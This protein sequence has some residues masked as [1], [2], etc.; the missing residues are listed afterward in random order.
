[1]P[2]MTEVRRAEELSRYEL[3]LEGELVGHADYLLVEGAVAL[4][5]VE[6]DPARGGQ[7]LASTLVEGALLDLRSRSLQVIPQCSF[8]AGYISKNPQWQDLLVGPG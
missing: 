5:H 3:L 8:A 2:N 1:M 4:T 7:G 6:T